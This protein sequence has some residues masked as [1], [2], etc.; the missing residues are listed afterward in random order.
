M[1]EVNRG[2]RIKIQAQGITVIGDVYSANFYAY[3]GGWYIEVENANVPGGYSYW[4][5]G[6]DGGK[7]LEING[8]P[9][10]QLS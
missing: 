4:K 1:I 5:Q 7:I 6:Q 2:D 3:D 9:I 10:E 8:V